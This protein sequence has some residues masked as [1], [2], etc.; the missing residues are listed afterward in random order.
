[1]YRALQ[2]RGV[3]FA[4]GILAENDVDY[5]VAKALAVE[6]VAVPAFAPMDEGAFDRAKAV[7]LGCEH[8][9]CCLDGFGELNQNNRQLRDE[10]AVRGKILP[11]SR[12]SD[13]WTGGGA[14]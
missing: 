5:A 6:T 3:P 11:V 12:L 9:I 2:R 10:A 14:G 8:V 1:M 7:M 4:A 13:L